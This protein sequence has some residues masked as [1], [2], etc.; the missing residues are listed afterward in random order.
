MQDSRKNI[1]HNEVHQKTMLHLDFLFR[2]GDD[3]KVRYFLSE[4]RVGLRFGLASPP[5]EVQDVL[6]VSSLKNCADEDV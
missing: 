2:L 1:A 5:S 6:L 3:T 4:K